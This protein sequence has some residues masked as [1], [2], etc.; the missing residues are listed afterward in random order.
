MIEIVREVLVTAVVYITFL[1][2]LPVVIHKIL[3]LFAKITYK[4][5]HKKSSKKNVRTYSNVLFNID[6]KNKTLQEIQLE[7]K[8][9]KRILGGI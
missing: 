6:S 7:R 1:F 8:L 4:K 2:I 5:S 9:M 3:Y